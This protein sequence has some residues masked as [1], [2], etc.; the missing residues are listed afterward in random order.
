MSKNGRW[1]KRGLRYSPVRMVLDQRW[2]KDAKGVKRL[3]TDEVSQED[4]AHRRKQPVGWHGGAKVT[5][6]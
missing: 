5:R 1:G 4:Y 6:R 2:V 3:V